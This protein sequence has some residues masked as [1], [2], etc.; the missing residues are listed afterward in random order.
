MLPVLA[1]AQQKMILQDTSVWHPEH[2]VFKETKK[3]GKLPWSPS[4]FHLLTDRALLGER[5]LSWLPSLKVHYPE[6]TKAKRRRQRPAACLLTEGPQ[7][8][9]WGF[10][11]EPWPPATQPVHSAAP[12]CHCPHIQRTRRTGSQA[13]VICT[14]L[15]WKIKSW[16]F[17]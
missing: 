6:R 16:L 11:W 4:L 12:P 17:L 1:G 14:H 5:L 8:P 7:L 2:F 9:S 10:T 13:T 3:A 15:S